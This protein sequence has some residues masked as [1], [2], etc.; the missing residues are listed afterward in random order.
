MLDHSYKSGTKDS[1]ECDCLHKSWSRLVRIVG[2]ESIGF[3]QS[4]VDKSPT[5]HEK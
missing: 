4:R 1:S 5:Q 3:M 2:A